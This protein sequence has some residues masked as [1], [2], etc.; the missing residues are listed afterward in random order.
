MTDTLSALTSRLR[1]RDRLDLGLL[2]GLMALGIIG[3]FM[4]YS[5]TRQPMLNAGYNPHY[6]LERQGL[7]VV[8]GIIVMYVISMFDYRRFEILATP[9][10]VISLVAL[11]GVFVVGQSSLGAQRWYNLGIIQI[12]PSEFTVLILILAVATYCHRRP[13]GLTMYDVVRILVMGGTPLAMIVLQPDLGT[14][15][16]I[17]LVISA[18]MVIAGVPPRFMSFL[19][20]V[21][22]IGVAG[23]IYFDL[24]HKYQVDRFVSFLNQNS[25]NPALAPLIYEVSNAKSAIGSGGLTGAGLFKG[26]QTVLGYV[27]EQRTDFIFTAIGEQLGFIGS[28]LIVLLLAFVAWRM[29]MI[30]RMAKDTMGRVLCLGVFIFFA[31]SCFENIGMTMGIMPVTGIPLPF[32]SYGGSAVLVFYAAGGLVLSVSR[33]VSN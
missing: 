3:A 19:A 13:E 17:V 33:R 9:L 25:T 2:W 26:L 32:L 30:G 28:V 10:Y 7:F 22:S 14:A 5:A 23:S 12:Q 4:I 18:M 27:P 31:F 15:I 16:I 11:A 20:V 1:A 21:G 6:Y 8:L 29:F 24:L